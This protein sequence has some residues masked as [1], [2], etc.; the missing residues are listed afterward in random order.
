MEAGSR[1]RRSRLIAVAVVSL[2][3]ALTLPSFTAGW[4]PILH[5]SCGARD[6]ITQQQG[7]VPA[8]LG[9][10]PY[11][12][13]TYANGT[14]PADIPG[15]P[16]YPAGSSRLGIPIWDGMAVGVFLDLNVSVS[17]SQNSTV[18]GPGSNVRCS[19]PYFVS[20]QAPYG[21]GRGAV[22]PTQIATPSNLSDV[23][24]ASTISTGGH[25][26]VFANGFI[27]ANHPPI[28]TC[29]TS[30][31][32]ENVTAPGFIIWAPIPLNSSNPTVP[33][34]L[35][36]EVDFHYLFPAN[37]GTWQIDDLSAPGGP[38]GGWAFS[39]SPCP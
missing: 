24:E 31:V 11:G 14:V 27:S 22:Q 38:G 34:P 26:F 28:S 37:F 5:S 2:I 12:G 9:N 25:S 6:S 35:P 39:Y 7:W 8:V 13:R 21:V 10:S 15:T 33:I 23:G 30:G 3:L 1:R 29:G 16:G 20:W 19:G 32:S 4:A 36:F 18:W 17:R